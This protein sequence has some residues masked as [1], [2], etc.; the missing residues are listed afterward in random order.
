LT[1]SFTSNLDNLTAKYM[2]AMATIS[3]SHWRHNV[4]H[5][6]KNVEQKSS[7]NSQVKMTMLIKSFNQIK[8]KPSCFKHKSDMYS[9]NKPCKR[10]F[11]MQNSSHLPSYFFSWVSYK[12]LISTCSDLVLYAVRENLTDEI[13]MTVYYLSIGISQELLK[14]S[15]LLDKSIDYQLMG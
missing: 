1:Q 7:L 2:T 9:Y 13:E 11:S 6:L 5:R 14:I 3:G 4:V 12:K 8:L 10:I 15:P